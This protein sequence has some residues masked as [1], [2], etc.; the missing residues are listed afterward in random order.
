[1]E[2]FLQPV[3]LP[4]I[5]DPD[6]LTAQHLGK[7]IEIAYDEIEN[8]DQYHI[9]LIGVTEDRGAINNTGCAA[10]PDLIRRQLYKLHALEHRLRIIDLGN[11]IPGNSLRDTYFA[12]TSVLKEL[13]QKKV[14]AVILGGSHDLTYAQYLA[15]EQLD[16]VINMVVVDEKVN[17][18]DKKKKVDASSFLF[19][20]LTQQPNYVFNF[21]L[22]GYQSYFVDEKTIETFQRLS[23]ECIRLG[24]VREN[25]EETEP[26][27]RDA[28]L[29]S[30]DLS[31]IKQSEAPG[32]KNATPNGFYSE[33]AC[34]IVR[35]AGLSDKL[36]SI[37]FYEF[38][39]ALDRNDQTSVLIAQM[40]WYFMEGV[41]SRQN[42][43]P[44][45][46]ESDYLK[47]IVNLTDTD[48]ELV[49]WKSK[50]SERWWFQI[51]FNLDQKYE[52]HQLIPCS[53]ADYK[54]ALKDE[55]PQRWLRAFEKYS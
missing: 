13:L 23:F 54:L 32:N 36:S 2:E 22:I 31:A 12:L 11:L 49:F 43:I 16:Q 35:Y 18:T 55:L 47:Y 5:I 1:M 19:R 8:L 52:R 30:F 27:V 28:D 3:N 25:I 33:E 38:N 4:D 7:R 26:M 6:S 21:N 41:A 40:I 29:L 24:K 14:V 53:Y 51:P 39:P 45:V 20:I 34:Q 37:G 42:D 46:N 48:H 17:I 15:Y 44:V 9:A 10:G 50:K